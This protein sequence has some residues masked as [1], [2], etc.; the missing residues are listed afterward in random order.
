MYLVW[1]SVNFDC[2]IWHI[3]C[4]KIKKYILIYIYSTKCQ[5]NIKCTSKLIIVRTFQNAFSTDTWCLQQVSLGLE[6]KAVDENS[7]Q[8]ADVLTGLYGNTGSAWWAWE[9]AAG[10]VAWLMAGQAHVF[11]IGIPTPSESTCSLQMLIAVILEQ[12]GQSGVVQYLM[13]TAVEMSMVLWPRTV[14]GADWGT[15]G[16]QTGLKAAVPAHSPVQVKT[17]NK[18]FTNADALG[19]VDGIILHCIEGALKAHCKN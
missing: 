3:L 5:F 12:R 19:P 14:A 6:L 8:F 7:L 15:V 2:H 10:V 18:R 17:G 16:H 13:W 1:F 9:S 11:I 4:N